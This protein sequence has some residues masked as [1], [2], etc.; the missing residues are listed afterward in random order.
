MRHILL[1]LALI[2][3]F[4]SCN[5]PQRHDNEK[6]ILPIQIEDSTLNLRQNRVYT[7]YRIPL[8]LELFDFLSDKGEFYEQILTPL[9]LKSKFLNDKHKALGLGVYNADLAYCTVLNNA[10][11]SLEYFKI[12]KDLA[13]ELSIEKGYSDRIFNR[14]KNNLDNFDSI[15]KITDE[16]FRRSCNYLDEN[17]KYNILPFVVVGGWFES[18]YLLIKTQSLTG[19]TEIKNIVINQADG[20]KNLKKFLYDVQMESSAYHYYK[21]LKKIVAKIQQIIE[22]YEKYQVV[23]DSEKTAIY[24]QITQAIISYRNQLLNGK[25]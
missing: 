6:Q 4:A 20:F 5:S 7:H 22:L 18:L 15:R 24:N 19:D 23:P 25:I 8:P 10:Q 16:A 11:A 14:L 3:V 21:D 13:Q 2:L 17:E 1:T 9:K 12:S